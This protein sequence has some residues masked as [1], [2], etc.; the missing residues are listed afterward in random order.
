MG[1]I[2]PPGIYIGKVLKVRNDP[3]ALFKEMLISPGARLD[4][5]E[6]VFVVREISPS[7]AT[8]GGVP[9]AVDR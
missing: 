1:G 2:F 8:I 3:H 4:R 7:A 5:L 6:E 9:D